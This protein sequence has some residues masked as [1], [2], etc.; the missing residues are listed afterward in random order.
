MVEYRPVPDEDEAAFR[1]VLDYAFRADSGPE[2]DHDDDPPWLGERRALYDG[3]VP[4]STAVRLPLE[5]TV[6]G[7]DRRVNGVSAVA[8]LPEHRRRG[9]VRRL[10]REM[11]AESRERE[12]PLSVLW[13]FKH[14]FYARLGWGRI[15]DVGRY[16]LEPGDLAPVDDHGLAGGTFR[17]LDVGD[18]EALQAVDARYAERADL[19]MR[20]TDEWYE[21]RFFEGW[22]TDPFVYGWE[23]DGELRGY[24]RYSV[25]DEGDDEVLQVNDFGAPDD[26]AAVNLLR[27]LHRH[28]G[29][30]DALR[31]HAPVDDQLFDLVEDPRSVELTVR[32]GP[33]GRLVD[34]AASLEALSAPDGIEATVTLAVE[35]R[36]CDWND[37]SFTV[38]AAGGAYHV[39]RGAGD[40]PEASLPVGT[41]S[42]LAVGSV[43]AERAALAGGLEGDDAAVEALAAAFPPRECY[44]REFF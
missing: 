34:V 24:V 15:S 35:D 42:R 41:L 29:Q 18:T 22:R 44:L 3:D 40:G 37:G 19:A 25:E 11:L 13:P 36:L 2:V 1:R 31:I 32:P 14:P 23:R 9:L 33:M 21:H 10:L 38:E 4:V 8:T 12:I 16:E 28:E 27:F 5:L 6:R 30:V 20:R 7:D 39:E 43:T 26:G 17:R